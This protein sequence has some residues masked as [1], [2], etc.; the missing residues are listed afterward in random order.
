MD[1]YLKPTN[2]GGNIEL[3]QN[4]DPQTTGGLYTA[5]YLS[6]F[7][8]PFWGN[9]VA[10]RLG[11]YQSEL[12]EAITGSLSNQ[13]RLNVIEASKQALA[14]MIESGIAQSIEVTAEIATLSRLNLL[15]VITKPS[16]EAVQTAYA[17]N[18]DAQEV[19]LI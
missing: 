10:G 8:N 1:L 16:G 13:T 14:W 17:L 15:V 5:V 11:R 2:D 18:W 19:E 12:S 9:A 7:T 3:L 6:L 4:G